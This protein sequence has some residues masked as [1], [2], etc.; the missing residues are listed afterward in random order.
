MG[1]VSA[2]KETIDVYAVDGTLNGAFKPADTL[3]PDN[4]LTFS[5]TNL[6]GAAG[7]K[8]EIFVVVDIHGDDLASC[9]AGS[10]ISPTCLNALADDD[11]DTSDNDKSVPKPRVI[12]P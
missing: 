1:Q 9:P 7:E 6:A 12:G 4:F 10:L 8:Y 2:P 5:C 3:D 11:A